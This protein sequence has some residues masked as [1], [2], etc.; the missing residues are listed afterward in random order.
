MLSR[1]QR[2]GS[3]GDKG[4]TFI[5]IILSVIIL[6]VGIIAVHRVFIGSL[7]ALNMIENR[8]QAERL[9]EKKMWEIGREVQESETGLSKKQDQGELHE[10][11]RTYQYEFNTSDRTDD[12]HLMQTDAS[13]FWENMGGRHS[14]KRSFYL[15]EPYAH[16]KK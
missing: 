10:N 9:L 3:S 15:M 6:S 7:A 1:E 2:M 5:E 8:S 4:F 14:I 11:G 16:W 12:G 13:I